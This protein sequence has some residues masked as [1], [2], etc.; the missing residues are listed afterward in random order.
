MDN[1][2]YITERI[3]P[4]NNG[5]TL[6]DNGNCE[7]LSKLLHISVYSYV[8]DDEEAQMERNELST[9]SIKYNPFC[10]CNTVKK[11]TL[12]SKIRLIDDIN[13]D[14]LEA[15]LK[16]IRDSKVKVVF[17]TLKMSLYYQLIVNS[18]PELSYIYISH[19]C[20][21][22]NISEDI[23]NFDRINN[24]D[25]FHHF[26]KIMR[27]HFFKSQERRM[28]KN[29]YRVFSI[30]ENDSDILAKHCGV[31][32]DKF[33]LCK[34]M[35]RFSSID[36]N[37]RCKHNNYSLLIVGNMSWYPTCEGTE[38][39]IKNVFP[40]IVSEFSELKLYVVGGGVPDR[41]KELGNKNKNIIVT[42]Y[43]D[44]LDDY[45][46][47]C[48]IAVVPIFSGTGAKIK[49]LEGVA[50]SIPLVISDYAAKDYL[51][52]EDSVLTARDKDEFVSKITR[53]LKEDIL[54]KECTEKERKFYGEYMRDNVPVRNCIEQLLR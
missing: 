50:K 2:I 36:N 18:F 8:T 7:F 42:G 31:E 51:G 16:E 3:Y 13:V 9:D 6:H 52:I 38:W 17:F 49:V 33:I 15:I 30:S 23:N 28:I 32:R 43:V 20:E 11:Y 10:R 35:I 4:F 53:L 34:P 19:N 21:F 47:N 45:Y 14:M 24:V 46:L 12:L 27:S 40:D 26:S 48:D 29:A 25:W 22:E 41:I 37:N 1:G 5:G 54:R 44:S 39:F